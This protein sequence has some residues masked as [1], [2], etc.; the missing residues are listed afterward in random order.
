MDFV[1]KL[2]LVAYPT[3]ALTVPAADCLDNLLAVV[4]DRAKEHPPLQAVETTT[5]KLLAALVVLICTDG[6]PTAG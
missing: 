4:T 5:P 1:T 6:A 2:L 3:C